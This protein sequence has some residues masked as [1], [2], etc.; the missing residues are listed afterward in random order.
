MNYCTVLMAEDDPDDRLIIDQV[1][2]EVGR[3]VE[4]WFVEDGEELMHY[5][6]RTENYTDPLLSPRPDFI[7]L[8][9]IMLN[10]L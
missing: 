1:I 7:L 10:K 4:L 3:R 9:R 2:L 8:E 6:R 5:L